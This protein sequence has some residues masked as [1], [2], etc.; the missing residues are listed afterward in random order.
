MAKGGKYASIINQLPKDLGTDPA[1][2]F[3]IDTTK[4]IILKPWGSDDHEPEPLELQRLLEDIGQTLARCQDI[5]ARSTKGSPQ[6]S[7]IAQ[8]YADVRYV[9]DFIDE[10]ESKINMLLKAYEQLLD[11]QYEVERV[12][13]LTLASGSTVRVEHQPHAR[14]DDPDKLRLWCI[15][16]GLERK[17]TIHWQT[18]NAITN[19]LLLQGKPEPAGVTATSRPKVVYTL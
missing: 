8:A 16:N 12:K 19:E 6:G 10:Y 2:Q 7:L 15:K 13:S 18:L 3:L 9:K 1:Y 14:I 17:L 11:T 4:A 5:L